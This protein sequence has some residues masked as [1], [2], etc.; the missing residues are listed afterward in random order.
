[1]EKSEKSDR[2]E[3][4]EKRE[5]SVVPIY[6]VGIFVFLYS[7]LLPMY[8]FSDL[9]MVLWLA[10]MLYLLLNK[11]F[12]GRLLLESKYQSGDR[13]VDNVLSQGLEYV[14]QL[15]QLKSA[16]QDAEITQRINS[17]Q[18][19]S[20]QIFEHIAKNPQQSSRINRFIS[21]YYP[22]ALKFLA[23]YQEFNDKSV[24]GENIQTTLQKIRSS[25]TTFEEA[26]LHQL[27]SLYS[28]KAI[29]I[30]TDIV[31]LENIMRSK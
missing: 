22:T 26:F 13:S 27:D 31:V 6:G 29:D 12:K 3:K 28:D 30:E 9:L 8:R 2:L 23:Q 10:I 1:M 21:Y 25:L 20:R 4:P 18:R 15:E 24:K 16:I 11:L 19:I 7:I 14:Q 5:R 17:M